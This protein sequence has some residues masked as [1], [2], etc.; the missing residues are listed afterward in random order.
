MAPTNISTTP[1][2]SRAGLVLITALI[3]GPATAEPPA[4]AP[5]D[6]GASGTI[7]GRLVWGD[8]VIPNLPLKVKQGDPTVKDSAVC[9][10]RPVPDQS[11]VV[12]PE[13]KGVRYG[14]A[15]VTAPN[16]KNP[17]AAAALL[18]DRPQVEMD[19]KGCVFTPHCVAVMAGQ[20]LVF[21]SS[22]PVGHNVRY[23]PLLNQANN[24]ALPPNGS[25]RVKLVAERNPI[26]VNCDIHNW[27]KAY[28]MVFDHPF[29]AVTG[30]DGSFEIRGVPAGPQKLIVR[31]EA[32][33]FVTGG[34]RS[35]IGVEVAPGTVT[36]VG[37]IKIDPA[38]SVK[39]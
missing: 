6:Q 35:G 4:A 18:A 34:G 22:D 36:D 21:K 29:F 9:A 15:Y 26:E 16:G 28:V 30:E 39:K 19:Q 33:G 23:S 10:A 37:E 20:A 24:V 17:E 27:M 14:F 13:T 12:D 2:A 5:P 3:A 7:K 31:Q 32:V 1:A 8:K 25:L 38:K 11:L